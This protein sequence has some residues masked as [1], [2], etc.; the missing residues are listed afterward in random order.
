MAEAGVMAGATVVPT[1]ALQPAQPVTAV[2]LAMLAR[3]VLRVEL[4][5]MLARQRAALRVVV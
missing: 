2:R 4:P 5:A 1:L 3:Q